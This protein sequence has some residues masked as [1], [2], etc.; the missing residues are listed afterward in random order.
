MI[1]I[2]MLC[3]MLLSFGLSSD[4]NDSGPDPFTPSDETI[5]AA[6]R[7]ITR[8]A[9]NDYCKPTAPP[10]EEQG[11]NNSFTSEGNPSPVPEPATA[12]LFLTGI[13]TAAGFRRNKK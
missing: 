12:L 11:P 3:L 10:Q 4:S 6:Q 5:A 9:H 1:Q 13:A 7:L 8:Y 2:L